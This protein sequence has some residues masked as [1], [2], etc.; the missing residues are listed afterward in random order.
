V[1]EL[2]PY[3][4]LVVNSVRNVTRLLAL[5]WLSAAAV[6]VAKLLSH[7]ESIKVGEIGFP[8]RDAWM[9]FAVLTAVH[10][11]ASKF[12]VNHI[13]EFRRHDCS[14]DGR[15]R[16]FDEIRA[17]R[18]LLVHG[19]I[20]RVQPWRLGSRWI[21]MDMRDPSAWA[22]YLGS[23][24][25]L[26]TILPWNISEGGQWTWGTSA[27]DWAQVGLAFVIVTVNWYAGSVWIISLSRL[28]EGRTKPSVSFFPEKEVKFSP[29]GRAMFTAIEFVLLIFLIVPLLILALLFEV[30]GLSIPDIDFSRPRWS[31]HKR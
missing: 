21:R 4:T 25:L 24:I 26:V 18:N 30:D 3:Q 12:L 10:L 11:A 2:N 17:D 15:A 29:L 28:A 19:L 23:I 16:I 5:G 8:I 27:L 22:S 6:L 1:Y 13:K 7:G 14:A 31:R 20:P 9:L